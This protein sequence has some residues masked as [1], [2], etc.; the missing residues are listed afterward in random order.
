ME[1]AFS[2]GEDADGVTPGSA[3]DGMRDSLF[4][5]LDDVEAKYNGSDQ[6]LAGESWGAIDEDSDDDD[7]FVTFGRISQQSDDSQP[8]P[9]SLRDSMHF[10]PRSKRHGEKI[11]DAEMKVLC[12]SMQC[13]EH[14]C[15]GYSGCR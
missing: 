13:F 3:F 7:D 4:Q 12:H 2:C 5:D 11:V 14:P 6:K 10:S 9:T 1:Q 8:G 15:R